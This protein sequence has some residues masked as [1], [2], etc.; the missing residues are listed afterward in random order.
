[1]PKLGTF[2]QP[3]A[4]RP[5]QPE[6]LVL[7]SINFTD[8]TGGVFLA[9]EDTVRVPAMPPAL[10]FEPEAVARS[11][12]PLVHVALGSDGHPVSARAAVR[13]DA[14]PERVWSEVID[15]PKYADRVPMIDRSRVDGEEVRIDLRFRISLFSVGFAFKASPLRTVS[16]SSSSTP[17]ASPRPAHPLR[18]RAARGL[19]L[20]ARVSSIGF[21]IFRSVGW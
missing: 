13:V 17:P 8:V 10:P 5:D 9:G 19:G 16:G 12:G 6:L 7:P 15:L 4:A 21:D 2:W 3:V 14:S 1:M 11:N 20:H 18:R